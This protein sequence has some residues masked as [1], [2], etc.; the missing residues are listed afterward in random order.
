MGERSM[1]TLVITKEYSQH[2]DRVHGAYD[3]EPR[4]HLEV[5]RIVQNHVDNAVSK[6]I[7]LPSDYPVE[8][9]D[10]LVK[11]YMPMVKG[12]T[13]YRNGSRSDEP[14][15]FIPIGEVVDESRY[16]EIEYDDTIETDPCESGVC[17]L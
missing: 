2:G 12:T 13:F 15:E 9:L 1:R 16:D 14:L 11:Q 4:A 3:L 8:N 6:T 10:S 17:A 5:Q 7:N